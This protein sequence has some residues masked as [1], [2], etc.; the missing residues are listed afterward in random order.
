IVNAL[1]AA[2]VTPANAPQVFGALFG[3]NTDA[4][5]TTLRLFRPP[6]RANPNPSFIAVDP[7][8]VEDVERLKATTTDAYELGYKGILGKRARLAIDLWYQRK[9][10]FTTAAQNVTPNA[11]LDPTTLGATLG[12]ILTAEAQ[13]GR[14]P[15]AA[16]APLAT[17]LTTQLAQ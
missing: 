2:G 6:N 16:I 17:A 13:A 9:T 15:A 1:L 8:S 10:N 5:Q 4:V 11:F 3:A 7:T 14:V 12:A